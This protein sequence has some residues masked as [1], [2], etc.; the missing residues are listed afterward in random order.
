MQDRERRVRSHQRSPWLPPCPGPASP[1]AGPPPPAARPTARPAPPGTPPPPPARPAGAPPRRRTP[2][3]ARRRALAAPGNP[4]PPPHGGPPAN[5]TVLPIPAGP[6]TTSAPP[7]PCWARCRHRPIRSNSRS[8][9][10]NRP[11]CSPSAEITNPPYARACPDRPGR[12][13]ALSVRP[14]IGWVSPWS[15]RCSWR[16]R[17]VCS[18]T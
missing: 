10:S 18:S 7:W 8:R 16:T 2:V 12:R 14:D 4:R 15:K 5:S 6:S 17:P 13:R 1:A 11:L 9:S 3:P